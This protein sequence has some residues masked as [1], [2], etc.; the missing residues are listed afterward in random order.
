MLALPQQFCQSVW[1]CLEC[2]QL[3]EGQ[4]Y[5]N[6]NEQV[7]LL[8]TQPLPGSADPSPRLHSNQKHQLVAGAWLA[9]TLLPVRQHQ[10]RAPLHP[11][12]PPA[13][14]S[15]AFDPESGCT[16]ST[17]CVICCVTGI[18]RAA[19]PRRLSDVPLALLRHQPVARPELRPGSVELESLVALSA[20][21]LSSSRA[22]NLR[23][24]VVKRT[25]PS[26]D[27]GDC[28]FESCTGILRSVLALV[29]LLRR[30]GIRDI[31]L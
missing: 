21:P 20:G 8:N 13:L 9:S 26:S 15:S 2:L 5:R 10:H 6:Q 27:F 3:E 1:L 7:R 12:G 4:A 30:N 18:F 11:A 28:G 24:A 16:P 19:L 31:L 29:S 25:H 23:M 22:R 17:T 14:L